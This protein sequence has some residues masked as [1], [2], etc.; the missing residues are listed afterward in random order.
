M[1]RLAEYRARPSALS[2]YLPWAGLVASGVVLN[3]D[4]SFQ[5]TARFRGPDLDSSSPSELIAAIARLNN[6]LRRLGSGWA[7][8]VEATRHEAGDYPVSTFP[9]ALSWLVDEERRA[10]FEEAGSHYDSTYRLTL[11]YLP[12]PESRSR[13]GR[14]LF[15]V[16]DRKDIDWREQ[17]DL[18]VTEGDRLFGLMEGVMPELVWMSDAETLTYLHGTVSTRMHPVAV[19]DVPVHLDA[20]LTDVAL[21]GGLAPMLG[22]HHLR[23][24]TVRGFP[25]ST[26]PGLLDELKPTRLPVSL[27]D[28]LPDPRQDRCRARTDEGPAPVVREAQEHCDAA[29][30]DDLPA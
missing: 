14:W 5:R 24:L 28:A 12:P 4:G 1:L 16:D 11:L 9:E 15:D 23:V 25:T 10:A 2:D 29:A 26:W 18:F 22:E 7:L 17:R 20:L 30:R 13:A 8:F 19:P 21:I 3:K 6:A 27:D